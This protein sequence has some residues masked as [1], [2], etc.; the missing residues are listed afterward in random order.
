MDFSSS[1]AYHR[2]LIEYFR[3]FRIKHFNDIIDFYE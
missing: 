1:I 3:E 2:F